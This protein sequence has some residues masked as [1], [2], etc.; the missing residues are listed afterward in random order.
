[1]NECGASH[2]ER[3]DLID[4]RAVC[5]RA[6][7]PTRTPRSSR[8]PDHALRDR[9]R[10]RATHADDPDATDARRRRDRGDRVLLCGVTPRR[11]AAG[12]EQDV[13]IFALAFAAA[14]QPGDL[15][16][17]HVDDAAIVRR[18]RLERDDLLGLQRL[19]RHLLRDAAQALDL[20]VAEATGVDDE[21][22]APSRP[23]RSLKTAL[24]TRCWSASITTPRRPITSSVSAVW[25]SSTVRSL[26]SLMSMS[27]EMPIRSRRPSR[28]SL[29][30]SAR[31]SRF[32]VRRARLSC[33]HDLPPAFLASSVVGAGP[34]A[35]LH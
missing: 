34:R 1:M 28:K 32:G 12:H 13:A 21:R 10:L 6:P 11:R 3:E 26:S 30:F 15:R 18:H 17:R 5:G 29:A 9:D 24:L 27:A 19:L 35:A 8:A 16:D 14:R 4:P 7:T 20:L 33:F 2:R 25:I 22:L 23:L 31:S